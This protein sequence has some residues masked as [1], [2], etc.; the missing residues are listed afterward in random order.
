MSFLVTKNQIECKF[1]IEVFVPIG[2]YG[3]PQPWYYPLTKTYWF[4][5]NA[6]KI[7]Q[8]TEEMKK[9][10]IDTNSNSKHIFI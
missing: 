5:Y 2:E 6:E 3:I 1:Y 7:R 9:K 10:Q 8:R 4:G